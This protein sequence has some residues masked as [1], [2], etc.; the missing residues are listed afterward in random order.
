M[1]VKLVAFR[2]YTSKK[3]GE[4]MHRCQFL[5]PDEKWDG[6]MTVRE[7]SVSSAMLPNPA[8]STSY[9]VTMHLCCWNDKYWWQLDS[10]IS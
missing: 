4:V 6:G 9:E 3:T 7:M 5:C 8:R 2:S 1:N 10:I